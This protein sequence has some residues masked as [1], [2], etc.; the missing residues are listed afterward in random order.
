MVF[1]ELSDFSEMRFISLMAPRVTDHHGSEANICGVTRQPRRVDAWILRKR[2]NVHPSFRWSCFFKC[3]R[4]G[5]LWWNAEI[6]E[7]LELFLAQRVFSQRLALWMFAAQSVF[8]RSNSMLYPHSPATLGVGGAQLNGDSVAILIVLESLC[9]I[10]K[11]FMVFI[12]IRPGCCFKFTGL[13]RR[14]GSP[15]RKQALPPTGSV[16]ADACN[17]CWFLSANVDNVGWP[18]RA[19]TFFFWLLSQLCRKSPVYAQMWANGPGLVITSAC[20]RP[21]WLLHILQGSRGD[22]TELLQRPEHWNN[23]F[24][25]E[26]KQLFFLF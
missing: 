6:P 3:I 5:E 18:A 26:Q 21:P 17:L 23:D 16:R 12:S 25:H 1:G 20:F 13:K 22:K 2:L 8:P 15:Q 10:N 19:D 14:V 9:G 7:L 11:S 24:R 4:P